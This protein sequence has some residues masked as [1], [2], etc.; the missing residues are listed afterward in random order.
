MA[1]QARVCKTRTNEGGHLPHLTEVHS[2]SQNGEA[3]GQIG[4]GRGREAAREGASTSHDDPDRKEDGPEGAPDQG[5]Q[6]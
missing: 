2:V 3:R 1:S 5:E 6:P 4:R